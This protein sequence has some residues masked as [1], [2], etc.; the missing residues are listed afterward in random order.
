MIV[1][2]RTSTA[3]IRKMGSNGELKGLL[4]GATATPCW[5][6]LT[7]RSY[8]AGSCKP[9]RDVMNETVRTRLSCVLKFPVSIS[10]DSSDFGRLAGDAAQLSG[11]FLT[12]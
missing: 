7:L 6:V 4:R 1:N 10:A 12:Q 3:T 8:P 2:P 5:V 11:T 9:V